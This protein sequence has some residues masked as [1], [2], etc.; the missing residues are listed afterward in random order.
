MAYGLPVV[1]T[2][3]SGIPEAVTDGQN[4]FLVERPDPTSLAAAIR[5]LI[6][7]PSLYERLSSNAHDT[8]LKRFSLAA[9]AAAVETLYREALSLRP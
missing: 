8:V 1:S 4:G 9:N 5:Q 6:D 2:R 7:N 3:H